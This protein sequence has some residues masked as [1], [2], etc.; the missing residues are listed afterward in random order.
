MPSR[1]PRFIALGLLVLT[2]ACKKTGEGE[3]QVEVPKLETETKT[4]RTPELEVT[5]ETSMV[6][7]PKIEV[8]KPPRDTQPR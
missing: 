3:Y 2:A 6:V 1:A 7:T 5:K 8:K 4:I